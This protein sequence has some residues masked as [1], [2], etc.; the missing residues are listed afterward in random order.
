MLVLSFGHSDEYATINHILQIIQSVWQLPVL[1]QL[2]L[3]FFQLI[4]G[5]DLYACFVIWALWWICNYKS[6]FTNYTISLTIAC[7][8]STCF[9]VFSV[10]FGG[11]CVSSFYFLWTWESCPGSEA[12]WCVDLIVDLLPR[13]WGISV[14]LIMDLFIHV[15]IFAVPVPRLVAHCWYS[16]LGSENS[17]KMEL[18]LFGIVSSWY[19]F[20]VKGKML[21]FHLVCIYSKR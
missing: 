14:D 6:H 8:D 11:C 13:I 1:I 20:T 17:F 2:V 7:V 19:A 5:V 9:V 15:F 10:N 4:F 21:D 18:V 3:L 16:T 12:S